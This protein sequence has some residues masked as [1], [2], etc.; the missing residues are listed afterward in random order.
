MKKLLSFLITIAP[1]RRAFEG[2][3]FDARSEIDKIRVKYD[4]PVPSRSPVEQRNAAGELYPGGLKYSNLSPLKMVVLRIKAGIDA[5]TRGQDIDVY[6]ALNSILFEE[7]DF[8]NHDKVLSFLKVFAPFGI[9]RPAEEIYRKREFKKELD[10]K[11]MFGRS[12]TRVARCRGVYRRGNGT[13]VPDVMV[14]LHK[15]KS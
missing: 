2:K 12:V 13:V 3:T 9:L 14:S 4:V 5:F 10:F 11:L 15:S 1:I 6:S 7:Q 8:D